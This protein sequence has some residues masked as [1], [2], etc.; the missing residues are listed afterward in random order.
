MA[1]TM[2]HHLPQLFAKER[3]FIIRLPLRRALILAKQGKTE[4]AL[5]R[6]LDEC[7]ASIHEGHT[8]GY[9]GIVPVYGEGRTNGPKA[10]N[11]L[12]RVG[13]NVAFL[14]DS[15]E[16]IQPDTVIVI[17]CLHWGGCV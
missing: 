5:C 16:P 4:E 8:F 2:T 7:W 12:R 9:L 6:V 14:G 10:A 13:Y 11:E 15:D 17:F 1:G 3:I